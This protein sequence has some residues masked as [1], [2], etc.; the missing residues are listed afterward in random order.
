MQIR[1]NFMQTLQIR[2]NFMQT[3]HVH[4]AYN[5]FDRMSVTV[6]DLPKFCIVSAHQKSNQ[7]VETNFKRWR[8]KSPVQVGINPRLISLALFA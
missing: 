5:L 1:I 8:F 7:Y 4:A 3:L 6:G 2:I